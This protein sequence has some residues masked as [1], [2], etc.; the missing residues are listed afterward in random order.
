MPAT[1]PSES[2]AAPPSLPP[3]PSNASP[4][5]MPARSR[6]TP[7]GGPVLGSTCPD[8]LGARTRSLRPLRSLQGQLRQRQ[9]PADPESLPYSSFVRTAPSCAGWSRAAGVGIHITKDP[10]SCLYQRSTAAC[11]VPVTT[12]RDHERLG[13]NHAGTDRPAKP[14]ILQQERATKKVTG[15][16]AA[17][18]PACERQPVSLTSMSATPAVMRFV[19]PSPTRRPRDW[20]RRAPTRR[21]T[22]HRTRSARCDLPPA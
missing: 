10:S 6:R 2:S 12:P 19:G 4:E 8:E 1:T 21:C 20:C 17:P 9:C 16:S 22:A 3:P 14:L 11:S 13:R 15:S 5:P 18:A 7:S